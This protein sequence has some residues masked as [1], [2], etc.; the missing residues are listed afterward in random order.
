MIC[1]GLIEDPVHDGFKQLAFVTVDFIYSNWNIKH[2]LLT[3]K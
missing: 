3:N 2:P 1:Y